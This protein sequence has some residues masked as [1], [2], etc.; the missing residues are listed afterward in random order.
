[1]QDNPSVSVEIRSYTDNKGEDAYNDE[2]SVKR[3]QAVMAYMSTKN[4]DRGRMV[5]RGEGEK[6]PIAPNDIKGKD[7]PTGRQY[8]RRTEFRI[9][10]DLPEKRIIYDM[11]RPEYIDKSGTEERNKNLQINNDVEDDGTPPDSDVR[12]GS[13]VGDDK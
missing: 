12:P 2:L 10:G 4:I 13:H 8:N 7:N 5:A 11:N 3:A 9:I 1:M 6:N